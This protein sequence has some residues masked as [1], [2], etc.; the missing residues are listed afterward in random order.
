MKKY[1]YPALYTTVILT[2]LTLGGC[3]KNNNLVLFS[4][5]NDKELGAQV[6]AEIAADPSFVILDRSTNVE[7]YSYL[8]GM[9]NEILQKG[10]VA[11]RNEFVWDVHIVH[12]DAVLNAFATPGGYIYVYTG[13]IKYLDEADDLAGVL[14]HEIAHADLRHTSRNLQ[15]LYGVQILLSILIGENASELTNIAGQIAGTVAGLSFSREFESEA[16]AR[17]VE[18]NANTIYACDGVKHFFEKLTEAGSGSGTPEFL[19]THPNP[20]T[21]VADITAKAA[22]L[23]CSTTLVGGDGYTDFKN[24]LPN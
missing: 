5:Q 10:D 24:T 6:S 18:Y 20:V 12:D 19:S 17:A 21:R 16:D 2:L 9:V 1:K 4:V 14:G 15:K 23:G 3:D 11:Y 13:L 7:A 8:D 22:E